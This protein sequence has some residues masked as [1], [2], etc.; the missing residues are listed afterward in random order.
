MC[1]CFAATDGSREH[2]RYLLLSG[3]ESNSVVVRSCRF[4]P[5]YVARG[6]TT[7]DPNVAIPVETGTPPLSKNDLG[8][9]GA[10]RWG[11]QPGEVRRG[12]WEAMVVQKLT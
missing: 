2:R 7:R 10:P 9:Y 1:R 11:G 8:D 5:F 12:G 3:S 6:A 4:A